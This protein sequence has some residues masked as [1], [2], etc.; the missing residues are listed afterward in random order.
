MMQLLGREFPSFLESVL[1]G[2]NEKVEQLGNGSQNGT[3]TKMDLTTLEE[4]NGLRDMW[5]KV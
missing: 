3:S 2:Q 1:G 4:E 5:K